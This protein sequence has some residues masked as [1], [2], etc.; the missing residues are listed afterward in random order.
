MHELTI[1]YVEEAEG[2]ARNAEPPMV[3]DLAAKREY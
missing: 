1:T 3:T 2:A